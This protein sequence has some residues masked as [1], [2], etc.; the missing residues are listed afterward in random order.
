MN[1]NKK[2]TA[3]SLSVLMIFSTMSTS[4]ADTSKVVTLGANL[5]QAQKEQVLKYFGVNKD[6]VVILEVNNQEER[7]YLEG[8]A[9]E[10]QLGNK[11]YSCAYVEPTT[12]GSGI[13]VKTA[14]LTWLT[15]SM[16]ASTLATTG[17][18]DADVVVASVFPVSGTGVKF[19]V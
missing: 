11:T 3:L 4:F 17:M 9:A 16:V 14:N 7:K 6:E 19:L 13:N 10:A 8:V 1:K 2:L 18:T 12:A 15:S 5:T